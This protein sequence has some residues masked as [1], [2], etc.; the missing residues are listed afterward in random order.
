[1]LVLDNCEHLRP[2]V[3]ELVLVALSVESDLRIVTTSREPL[4]VDGERVLV[5]D[6]LAVPGGALDLESSDAVRLFLDRAAS[7]GASWPHSPEVLDQV[8]ELCRRLDG[9]PLAIELA[10]AR[11][12]ALSPAELLEMTEQ[13]LDVL[14]RRDGASGSRHRSARG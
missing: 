1:I 10:A 13:S 5:V 14:S 3:A 12:R 2:S 7:A 6:P 8:G 11:S 4:A 9:L